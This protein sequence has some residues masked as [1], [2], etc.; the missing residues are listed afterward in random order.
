MALLSFNPAPAKGFS[1]EAT[2]NRSELMLE[3]IEDEYFSQLENVTKVQITYVSSA[4]KQKKKMEFDFS[5]ISPKSNIAFHA[6]ARSTFL[7]SKVVLINHVGD[8]I[9]LERSEI[10]NVYLYDINLT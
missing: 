6:R 4:G 2:L 5:D 3:I 10:S 7:L 9:T 8:K 1:S